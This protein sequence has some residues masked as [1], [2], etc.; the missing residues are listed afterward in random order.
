MKIFVICVCVVA[1]MI[2]TVTVNSIFVNRIANELTESVESLDTSKESYDKLVELWDKNSSF[3]CLSASTK[4]TDKIEDMIAAI[5]S[6]Y[7]TQDFS[8]LEEKKSLLIN[9]IRLI[10]NHERVTVSNI[11]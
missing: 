8:G 5:G 4:E 10:N 9:Y 2:G 6:V 11:I 1:L 3:L 7:K